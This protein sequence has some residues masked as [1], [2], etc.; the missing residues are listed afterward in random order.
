MAI[1]QDQIETKTV[2]GKKQI[3]V[4]NVDNVS[5]SEML[6]I[7]V[8]QELF[9]PFIKNLTLGMQ[10]E[11]AFEKIPEDSVVHAEAKM[12]K[13]SYENLQKLNEIPDRISK[14]ITRTPA[15]QYLLKEE[16]TR[17]DFELFEKQLSRI[18]LDT[19]TKINEVSKDLFSNNA[20]L[21]ATDQT[22]LP[23]YIQAY[24]GKSIDRLIEGTESECAIC[25][26]LVRDYP[27][28]VKVD[29]N[30]DKLTL[31]ANATHSPKA[32]EEFKA[33]VGVREQVGVMTKEYMKAKAKYVNTDLIA[34][35]KDVALPKQKRGMR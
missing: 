33:L 14:D 20:H 21:D 25:L 23:Q 35:I 22:L 4:K 17:K 15:E 19:R 30:Y 26:K 27:G 18:D 16:M 29:T 28:L 34:E 1:N 13:T 11:I 32:F 6:N 9:E 10:F 8:Q 31:E 12:L 7:R 3:V 2:N 24:Q 5:K